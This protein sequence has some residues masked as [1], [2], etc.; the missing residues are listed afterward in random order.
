MDIYILASCLHNDWWEMKQQQVIGENAIGRQVIGKNAI[1][2]QVVNIWRKR[3]KAKWHHFLG[4]PLC[5][6]GWDD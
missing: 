4:S 1:G 3:E 2:R 6:L 5:I